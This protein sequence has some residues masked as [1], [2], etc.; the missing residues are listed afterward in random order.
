MTRTT[1]GRLRLAIQVVW[2]AGFLVGTTSHVLDLIAGGA[3]T[4]GAFPPALRAFWLSL[5]VLD[6]VTALLLLVRKRAGIILGVVVI[7]TDISVNWTDFFA[8]EVTPEW[9]RSGRQRTMRRPKRGYRF[10]ATLSPTRCSNPSDDIYTEPTAQTP[11]RRDQAAVRAALS[12]GGA[13]QSRLKRRASAAPALL[14]VRNARVRCT[15]SWRRSSPNASRRL[16][17]MAVSAAST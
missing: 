13:F 10:R 11:V 3:D 2:I 15:M 4:Y 14:P 16:W 8:I 7:L 12:V 17:S 9:V 5:T 1:A 6:P